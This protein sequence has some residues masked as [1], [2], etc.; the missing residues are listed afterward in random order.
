[1][2][3]KRM[4]RQCFSL[5]FGETVIF[6]LVTFAMVIGLF[7]G[8]S[9][10]AYADPSGTGVSSLPST[11]G[12]YY[13]TGDVTISSS[14]TPVNGITLDLNGKTITMNESGNAITVSNGVTLTIKDSSSSNSGKITHASNITGRGVQVQSGG[15]FQMTGGSITANNCFGDGAGVYVAGAADFSKTTISYNTAAGS[16]GGI[17]V[18]NGGTLSV[19][20][21][22]IDNNIT[23]KS[24]GSPC[25][26]GVSVAGTA[27]FSGNTRITNN[28]TKQNS[29]GGIH[30][31]GNNAS[32]TIH[33]N[34]QITGNKAFANGGGIFLKYGN[35][36]KISGA[37]VIKDNEA[38][39]QNTQN[40]VGPNM[41]AEALIT[42]DGP[43]TGNPGDIHI[44]LDL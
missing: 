40:K 29:G 15:T 7:P 28:W 10:K 25:G 37:P 8:M 43:L 27:T 30:V 35:T 31:S 16:G 26:G 3:T 44:F 4:G 34:V 14:W 23:D 17:Y 24:Y 39:Y 13:L 22:T 20:D 42:I 33:D 19:A 9:V 21:C 5:P 32:I 36:M 11:A 6:I 12:T 38:N 18:H 1:M 2:K 41:D